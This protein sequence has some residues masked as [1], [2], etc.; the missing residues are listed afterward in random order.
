MPSRLNRCHL[1][2]R[3]GKVCVG[4]SEYRPSMLTVD[5]RIDDPGREVVDRVELAS[6]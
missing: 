6:A 4:P 1:L 3:K 2:G 5:E